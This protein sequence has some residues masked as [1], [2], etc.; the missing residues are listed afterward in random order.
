MSSFKEKTYWAN[1]FSTKKGHLKSYKNAAMQR[2]RLKNIPFNLTIGHIE[3]IATDECPVFKMPFVWGVSGRGHGKSRGPNAPSLDRIIPE[4]GYVEGNV[5]FKE[6]SDL[7]F[8]VTVL[9]SKED[10]DE[11]IRFAEKTN[12]G[13]DGRI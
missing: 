8:P 10:V 13:A 12:A 4:L 6:L 9:R 11:F 1:Y 5:V 2:A 3:S 7:G